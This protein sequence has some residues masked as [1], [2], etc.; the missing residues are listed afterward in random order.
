MDFAAGQGMVESATWHD[1]AH[2]AD[3]CQALH[4]TQPVLVYCVKGLDIGRSSA[5]ALSASGFD[6]R[7]LVGGVNAWRRAGLPMQA[8]V[9]ARNGASDGHQ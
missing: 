6:A 5:L 1:P 9:S 2:L 7:Y 8:K 4:P 3:W